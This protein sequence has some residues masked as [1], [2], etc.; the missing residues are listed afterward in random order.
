[1]EAGTHRLR[2]LSP[3]PAHRVEVEGADA[4]DAAML[5]TSAAWLPG[6]AA[7]GAHAILT[8]G[9]ACMHR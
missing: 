2:A 7:R 9:M 5:V 1:M 8:H 3:R 6:P 4:G